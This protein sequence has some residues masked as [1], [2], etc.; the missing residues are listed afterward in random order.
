MGGV[1]LEW[2]P[3]PLHERVLNLLRFEIVAASFANAGGSFEG[4]IRS[5]RTGTKEP[6]LVSEFTPD[7][8]A[9]LHQ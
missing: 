2:L 4:V 6:S 7:E 8:G 3:A 9:Y 1:G 5:G